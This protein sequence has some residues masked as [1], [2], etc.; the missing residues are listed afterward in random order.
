MQRKLDDLADAN[1]PQPGA[2]LAEVPRQNWRA[3]QYA[4]AMR[5]LLL[6]GTTP[7]GTGGATGAA[8]APAGIQAAAA[9]PAFHASGAAEACC[10]RIWAHGQPAAEAADVAVASSELALL[11]WHVLQCLS[12]APLQQ[13]QAAA[14]CMQGESP[15]AAMLAWARDNRSLLH[16]D[17]LGLFERGWS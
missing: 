16:P 9:A 1:L 6:A 3:L 2:S 11:Q 17:L 10:A 5:R 13:L 15:E 4:N 14:G 12:S 7:S 8:P